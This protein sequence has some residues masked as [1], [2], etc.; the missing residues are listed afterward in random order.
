[1]NHI[2]LAGRWLK[3]A[4]SDLVTAMHMYDDVHPKEL[5]ISC[6][7]SQ[8][9]VEKAYTLYNFVLDF[10]PEFGDDFRFDES[11]G[12]DPAGEDDPEENQV[13]QLL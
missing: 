7:H 3:K 4:K 11:G 9:T 12:P 2:D 1:M 5:D 8:Q 6:Y 13:M 10:M